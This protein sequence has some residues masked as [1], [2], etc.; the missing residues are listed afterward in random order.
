MDPSVL[1]QIVQALDGKHYLALIIL[2]TLYLRKLASPTSKFPLNIPTTWLSTVSAFGGLV[3]GFEVSL[4]DGASAG[5]AALSALAIAAST[6]FFDGLMTAIFAHGQAPA[7]AKA[8]VG[9][10]DDVAGGS[11]TPGT[12]SFAKPNAVSTDAQKPPAAARGCM[13]RAVV[14]VAA[15]ALMA[16]IGIGCS[17]LQALIPEF[18]TIDNKIVAD[19][20]A[21]DTDVQVVTDVEVILFGT[22]PPAQAVEMA[23]TIA[24]DVLNDLLASGLLAKHY[25]TLVASATAMQGTLAV[26]KAAF[27][28]QS[29]SRVIN[30]V[31]K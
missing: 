16:A 13:G 26:K 19:L 12:G 27:A 17:T 1:T 5:T 21:G 31:S 9:V 6:G 24:L 25:P 22:N 15:C 29:A 23:T 14:A 10:I 18:T 20:Q 28:T 11:G 3:Y 8:I 2:V 4:Q 7:W 30:A